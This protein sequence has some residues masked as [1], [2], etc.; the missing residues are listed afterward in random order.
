MDVDR[1]ILLLTSAS[2]QDLFRFYRDTLG[3]PEVFDSGPGEGLPGGAVRVGGAVLVI[4]GHSETQGAA[5]EPQRHFMDFHVRDVY[6]EQ[7]R[8]QTQGVR[9]IR[10]A[11]R[12]AWGGIIATFLDP[13]GNFLQLVQEPRT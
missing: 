12:E 11:E 6:S 10:P 4:E 7:A 2:P 5:M 8:L 9:F 13:D 3:L 1:V